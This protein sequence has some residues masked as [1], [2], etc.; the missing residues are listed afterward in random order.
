VSGHLEYPICYVASF[1]LIFFVMGLLA[2]FLEGALNWVSLG[3]FNSLAGGVAGLLITVIG[4]SLFFNFLLVFDRKSHLISEQTKRES[5]LFNSVQSVVP[6]FYP[7]ARHKIEEGWKEYASPG[8]ENEEEQ[9][10]VPVR[11]KERPE[12]TPENNNKD[13]IEI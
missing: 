3:C 1:V 9:K 12:E 4:F 8:G 5:V 6:A 13:I 10:S 11:P 2:R 7:Y